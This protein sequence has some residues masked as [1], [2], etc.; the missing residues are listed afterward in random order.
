MTS[1]ETKVSSGCEQLLLG[2][3]SVSVDADLDPVEVRC[4]PP[5]RVSPLSE[6]DD[7]LLVDVG[8][9]LRLFVGSWVRI[10]RLL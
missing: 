9:L 6:P 5:P 4:P 1:Q 3:C 7:P 8:V 10:L 2:S